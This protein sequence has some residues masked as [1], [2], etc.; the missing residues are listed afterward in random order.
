MDKLNLKVTV[1]RDRTFGLMNHEIKERVIQIHKAD[2]K[3]LI[4]PEEVRKIMA[5]I[6]SQALKRGERIKTMVKGLNKAR[7]VC[8]KGFNTELSAKDE[9]DYMRGRVADGKSFSNFTQLQIHIQKY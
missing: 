5:D 7:F 2:N 4:T 9:E 1:E 3:T 8:L 6:E